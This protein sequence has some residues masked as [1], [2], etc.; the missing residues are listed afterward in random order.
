MLILILER[1]LLWEGPEGS[2][3][4]DDALIGVTGL[5]L[6]AWVAWLFVRRYLQLRAWRR[7]PRGTNYRL[8][9]RTAKIKRELSARYLRPPLSAGIHAVGIGM[10]AGGDYC[11]QVFINDA[12]LWAAAGIT[13]PGT[14][15]GVRVVPIAMRTAVFLSGERVAS[16]ATCN[17][18]PRGIREYQE[19]IIGGISG[20][21]TNLA[22]ES[23]TIGYF[24]TRRSKLPRR[25]VVHI[26]SNWHVF[27]NPPKAK[28]EA[29]DLIVQPSPGEPGTNRPVGTLVDF[30]PL[31]F[32]GDINEPNQVDAAIAKLW[33]PVK[34]KPVIPFIGTVKGYVERKDIQIGEAVRKSGRTTRYTK[35]HVFSVC[36]DIWI[37]YPRAGQSAFFQDQVLVEPDLPQFTNFVS[38][39][40]SGSLLVDEQQHAIG[41]IFAGMDDSQELLRTSPGTE[42]VAEADSGIEELQRVEGYGV[43]NPISEVLDRLKIDLVV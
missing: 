37:W 13:L 8:L 32:D 1:R 22:N 42:T 39:G 35:G 17:K 18:Y 5:L 38:G 24:C 14:Y 21:N 36:L 20:A 11:I 43:A 9:K 10:L 15:R 30:L 31:K 4:Y 27:G 29:G 7:R 3:W 26:L 19:V 33:A 23:G 12:R 40:D 16:P 28:V 34:H 2:W 41:L 25:P 6:L